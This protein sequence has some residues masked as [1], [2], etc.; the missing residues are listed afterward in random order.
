MPLR[1]LALDL[2]GTLLSDRLEIHPLDRAAVE[3]AIDAGVAVVLVTGR[4][5]ASARPYAQTLGLRGPMINFHGAIIRDLETAQVLYRCELG[6]EAQRRVLE[7]AEARDW[8]VNAYV[9]DEIYTARV[10][11][12]ADLYSRVAGVAYRVVGPLSRWV[13][14]GA[15]KMVIVEPD[16]GQVPGRIREL[17]AWLDGEARVTRSLPWFIDVVNPAVSK[18][19]ALASVAERLDVAQS[20][21][22]AIGD[23]LN[24]L[25]MLR[26]AGVGVAMGSAPPEVR[27]AAD[28]VSGTPL[29]AGV[30]QAVSRLIFDGRLESLLQ[31]GKGSG[32]DARVKEVGNDVRNDRDAGAG[33]AA[34]H[35]GGPGAR[36]GAGPAAGRA[37]GAAGSSPGHAAG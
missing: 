23:N 31:D 8:H 14:A 2:D 4:T 25:E 30:A 17:A 6:V 18:A 33:R 26:W 24:D 5:F 19:A 21:V 12:E 32:L 35:G 7:Y 36:P 1:L 9:D 11:P 22:C 37:P 29:E 28:L 15:S 16:E 27:A 20:E 13:H 34:G 10:R 3:A